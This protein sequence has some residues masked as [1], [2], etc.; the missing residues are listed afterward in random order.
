MEPQT[1]LAR[2]MGADLGFL[3]TA[4][5]TWRTSCKSSCLVC[6][7]FARFAF[8]FPVFC[9]SL[10]FS[11][12]FRQALVWLFLLLGLPVLD[13]LRVCF[14]VSLFGGGEMLGLQ[15]CFC[16]WGGDLKWV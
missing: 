14:A 2:S 1:R 6:L 3:R 13:L 7:S 15:V 11:F 10:V 4:S 9:R 12:F 16:A 5:K 8:F